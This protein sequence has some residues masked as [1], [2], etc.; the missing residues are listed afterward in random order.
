MKQLARRYVFWD[1][2]NTDIERFVESCSACA[3]NKSAPKAA[4]K[5][6]WEP[7]TQNFE[8]VHMD[9]AGPIMDHHLF[10]LID[11][12]SKWAEIHPFRKAP[13]SESTITVLK[14]IFSRHGLPTFLVSDNATIFKSA[15]FTA[16]CNRNGIQQRFI[17]P[18]HAATNG[19]AERLVQTV[20][21]RL[22]AMPTDWSLK[23]KI[24]SFLLRYHMTPLAS[25]KTPAELYLNRPIRSKF[26]NLFPPKQGPFSAP[27]P[28]N[29]RSLEVGDSV[30]AKFIEK[31]T[32]ME[33]RGNPG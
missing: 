30:Y 8:R 4:P 13:T 25:G 28:G 2:I 1:H 15:E 22:K 18:L 5:H 10:L 33:R 12:R 7:P 3:Q 21:Q 20:K 16:F 24:A 6:A 14:D 17:A 19:Q 9:F 32:P 31:Q 11:A 23:E 26:D 29:T 27:V